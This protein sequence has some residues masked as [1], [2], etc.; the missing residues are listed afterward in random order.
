MK[1]Y[2]THNVFR[3]GNNTVPVVTTAESVPENDRAN[4]HETTDE[5]WQAYEQYWDAAY[6]EGGE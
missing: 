1:E 3:S 5:E 4:W 2:L 6:A